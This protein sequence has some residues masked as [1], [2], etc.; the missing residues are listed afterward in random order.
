MLRAPAALAAALAG[1]AARGRTAAVS[2]TALLLGTAAAAAA[3]LASPTPPTWRPRP[4]TQPRQH[5][6]RRWQTSSEA[7]AVKTVNT[8]VKEALSTLDVPSGI[9][10]AVLSADRRLTVALAVPMDSGEVALFHAH[11]VQHNN[12]RGPYKGGL[13]FHPE[14]DLADVEGLASLN[15]WQPALMGVPFGGAKG[16]VAV[17]PAQLSA[18]ELEKLTRWVFERVVRDEDEGACVCVEKKAPPPSSLGA[19]R[20]FSA[21]QPNA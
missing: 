21:Q 9:E 2:S 13:K 14:A 7:E 3:P 1:A 16:G 6:P 17:D 12:A 10:R 5:Q 4:S 8:F 15:T 19:S 18:R 20:L 11:R